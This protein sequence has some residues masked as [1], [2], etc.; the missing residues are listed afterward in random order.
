VT[1]GVRQFEHLELGVPDLDEAVGFYSD[2]IGMTELAREDGVVYLG[3]G[4]DNN[5]DLALTAGEGV[6]HFAFR[7]DDPDEIEGYQRRLETQN[8]SYERRDGAEFGQTDAVRFQLPSGHEMEFVTV[9]DRAEYQLESRHVHPRTRGIL[10]LDNDHLGLMA[11]D[12][13]A[14]SEFFRDVLDFK[15]SEYVVPEPGSDFWVLGFIRNGPYHHDISI[16]AGDRSLHHYAVTVSSFEHIKVACDMLAGSGHP[17]EF[18]PSRHPAGSNLFI[19]VRLPGGHRVEF[20]AEMAFLRDDVPMK[21]LDSSS[22]MDAWGETWK[23]IP[24]SFFEGS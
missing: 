22:S 21:G 9:H 17:I 3:F 19:Y 24:E 23:R 1:S 14:L 18:G 13:Q 6:G 7:V 2:I 4:L 16:A 5:Y 8:I 10:P 11:E 20:S 12:V 15:I